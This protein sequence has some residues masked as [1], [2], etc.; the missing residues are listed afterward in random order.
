VKYDVFEK[1]IR[2]ETP[3]KHACCDRT[4]ATLH[5]LLHRTAF[6]FAPVFAPVQKPIFAP[7]FAEG[8]T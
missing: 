6:I 2:A 7:D 8:M 5:P 1:T 3:L 4:T